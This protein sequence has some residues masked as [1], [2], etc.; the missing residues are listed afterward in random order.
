[1]ESFISSIKRRCVYENQTELQE[2]DCPIMVMLAF[3]GMMHGIT[4][5]IL[6][7]YFVGFLGEQV[8]AYVDFEIQKINHILGVE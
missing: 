8:E 3:W 7:G 4:S 5:L 6:H 2:P 1:M